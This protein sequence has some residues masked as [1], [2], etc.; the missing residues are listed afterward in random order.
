[1]STLIEKEFPFARLSL[2]AERESWRK[3]VYRPVYYLHKWW[4]RRLGSVFRG[5]VLGACLEESDDFWERFYGRNL[6]ADKIVLDPFM[7][8]GVTLGEA[9][10]L[11]CRVIG[12]DINP[13]ARIAC[14]AAFSRYRHT[15]VLSAYRDLEDALAPRLLSYFRTRTAAGEEACVLYYFLVK[16]VTCPG[17]GREVELFKTRVFSRNAVP[18]KDPSARSCCPGC[19]AVNSTVYDSERVTCPECALDYN[20]QA[21]NIRGA[22]VTCDGCGL[23]FRL[24][25]RMKS[26]AGP[27]PCR[28]Y[29][30]MVLTQAGQKRYEPLNEVDRELERQVADEFTQVAGT[31]PVVAIEPGYNTNQILKHNYRY[32]HQLFSDRQ[33]VCIRQMADAIKAIPEPDLRLLFACLFSGTLEFNNLFASFKGEGTGAVRHMFAHHVL[34]PETMPLEANLWGTSKSSGAFSCLFRSRVERA[35]AYKRDPFELRL[36]SSRSVKVRGINEPIGA[37]L[38]EDFARFRSEPSVAFI[39]SGDSSR[40]DVSDNSVDL[41]VTD[42]PFFDNVHY[43]QLADFFYYW[44]NQILDVSPAA[45]TRSPDEVQDT[46]PQEFTRKL[47]AVFA[48][49]RRVLRDDG[50]LVFTYHHSRHEGWTAVHRAIRHSGFVC[51]QAY[52]IK[53]EMSVSMP[54]Q[55]AKSPIHLDLIL[56]CRKDDGSAPEPSQDDRLG[57]A[58]DSAKA[59]IASLRGVGIRVS[60][61][62]A[63]VILMGSFLCQAHKMRDLDV[64]ESFLES[65]EHEIDAYVGQVLSTRGEVLYAQDQPEPEQLMLFEKMAEYL[66][67]K[68]KPRSDPRS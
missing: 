31:F 48:E 40:T 37:Q 50:L 63:M 17:C 19:G 42:P 64:E 67:G 57:S 23:R 12:R 2:L 5:I 49:C 51:T 35:L 11:G 39:T 47:T 45:T 28:R 27:L 32:W 9:I 43:S 58:L 66:A 6:F 53:A 59:Q 18:R 10:K 4:A 65:L 54:L 34:K 21:G 56:V 7:G 3:E 13:V 25:D 41:V 15:D 30:K 44:L 16:V 68:R 8:S 46:E 14:Q 62:D 1:M 38:V 22:E 36:N 55:Q 33:L 60:L 52:P 29:A 24:V 26:L 20:P 61:G